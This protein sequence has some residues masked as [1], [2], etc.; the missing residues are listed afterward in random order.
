[1]VLII[2]IKCVLPTGGEDGKNNLGIKLD[3]DKQECEHVKEN[4]W[5]FYR[6]HVVQ[7]INASKSERLRKLSE[8]GH[9]RCP[10]YY[11]CKHFR[12]LYQ[13]YA[14]AELE[15]LTAIRKRSNYSAYGVNVN[16]QLPADVWL[17]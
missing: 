5:L 14:N 1:M 6:Q 4:F 3:I 9:R 17:W 2:K 15:E 13:S 10:N 8:R 16:L 7:A 11:C 12:C